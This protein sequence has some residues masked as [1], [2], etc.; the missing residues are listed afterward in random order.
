MVFTLL[1]LDVYALAGEGMV[2]VARK[3]GIDALDIV[4][5]ASRRL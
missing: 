5:T 3:L 2:L 4:E 1:F